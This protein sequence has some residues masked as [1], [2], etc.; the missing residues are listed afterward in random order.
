MQLI[1]SIFI[2]IDSV[3]TR[4]LASLKT[5]I[6]KFKNL[7]CTISFQMH[8]CCRNACESQSVYFHFLSCQEVQVYQQLQLTARCAC[9][10]CSVNAI[11][12]HMTLQL[13][14]SNV[15]HGLS[16]PKE[17]SDCV[18]PVKNDKM[19]PVPTKGYF[20]LLS[21]PCI[22]WHTVDL[23]ENYNKAH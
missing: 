15:H 4:Q 8:Q 12:T 21:L 5:P 18:Q 9:A 20:L 10:A 2:R 6:D 22:K 17:N 3:A 13:C 11:M 19:L 7:D 1:K 14:T 16:E 23:P